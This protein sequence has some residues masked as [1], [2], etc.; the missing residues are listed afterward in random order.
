MNINAEPFLPTKFHSV[1]YNL[2]TTF[3]DFCL[4]NKLQ[5]IQTPRVMSPTAIT[6]TSNSPPQ[7]L[8]S[9]Q[10]M[11]TPN[12]PDPAAYGSYT[13]QP[14][15]TYTPRSMPA[16]SPNTSQSSGGSQSGSEQL[17]K[18]NLYIRGLNPNTT[19]KDLVN[20][21]SPYGKII[22]TKAIV[23][24]TT[25][26]CKGYGFVDFETNQAAEVAVQALQAQG[27]QAQ[28]AKQQEQDPTNLYI[29]N[30]PLYFSEQNLENM[31]KDYG[32]VIST[33]I[34]R[35]PDGVSRG[36]GFARMESKEK[37]EQVINGFNGKI[38]PG[39]TEPLLAK[40]ADGGN[41]KK[42]PYIQPT[43]LWPDRTDVTI[44][45]LAYDQAAL[46]QNGLYLPY[47]IAAP[48]GAALMTPGIL[49]RYSVASSPTTYQVQSNPGAFVTPQY[50]MQ[51]PMAH[52]AALT[53]PGYTQVPYQ[54]GTILQ[55]V[56]IESNNNFGLKA[57]IPM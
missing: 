30:L 53:T 7:H 50:I 44:P 18:T 40:F 13:S 8:W 57:T 35:K 48:G 20:L 56:P 51:P 24:Q 10:N 25:N 12:Q 3:E 31:L 32:T 39:C 55:T 52:Y 46:A 23:D 22:S 49:P 38:L 2:N 19:D 11:Y 4:Q 15:T 9:R 28:M 54:A 33:R 47:S 21:C 41:K 43:K 29:A 17:S 27:I 6:A 26:K 1:S 42:V 45:T 37:C 34:L 16:A 5:Y 14:S 36:V